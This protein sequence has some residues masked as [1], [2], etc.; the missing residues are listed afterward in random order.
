MKVLIFG[1]GLHNGGL[2]AALYYA[3]N[4]H[5]VTVTDLFN[6]IRLKDSVQELKKYKIPL[7]LGSHIDKDF[8]EADLIIKNPAIHP[9]NY[10]LSLNPHITTDIIALLT[11]LSKMSDVHIIA[12][13][14]TKGKSSTAHMITHI[15]QTLGETVFI[16]GNI[17]ISG[18]SLIE[19]IEK[20]ISI[21]RKWVVLELSSWQIRDLNLYAS[22]L[23]IHFSSIIITSLYDDHGDYYKNTFSYFKEKLLL[24]RFPST[25]RYM[26]IQAQSA[27]NELSIPL[28]SHTTIIPDESIV[29][30]PLID[31]G[32]ESSSIISTLST[33]KGLAHRREIVR[34]IGS[35]VWINDS[36]ATIPEAMNHSLSMIKTP[37]ILIFGGSD[38]GCHIDVS[39]EYLRNAYFLILLDGSFT[40]EKIVPLLEGESLRYCGPFNN[41]KEAVEE[42]HR[43]ALSFGFDVTVILSPGAAS[44][45]V[46]ANSDERGTLFK[47]C[48]NQ[49]S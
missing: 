45:G 21:G 5:D 25:L 17:G 12:V 26:S 40:R 10:Y 14:G 27:L 43:R 8:L 29:I 33:Y 32:F 19:E 16:G 9:N 1:L 23:D 38:K 7:H 18:F 39:I 30:T 11:V 4:N 48:V 2:S 34:T 41:I 37:Y 46:F 24:F 13:S 47:E 6:E 28:P 31:L 3:K 20:N 22:L 35:T 15:L 49:L 42:S 44:F 36:S